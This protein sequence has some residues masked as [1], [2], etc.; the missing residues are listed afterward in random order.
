MGTVVSSVSRLSDR[1]ELTDQ[2][3]VRVTSLISVASKYVA[4]KATQL[5]LRYKSNRH[6]A[7]LQLEA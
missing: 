5:T 3:A 6:Q 7:I 1:G 4:I 2:R